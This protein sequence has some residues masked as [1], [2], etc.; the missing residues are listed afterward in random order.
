MGSWACGTQ[1]KF[2]LLSGHVACSINI[3][4]EDGLQHDSVG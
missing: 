2:V 3:R 1:C 4:Q